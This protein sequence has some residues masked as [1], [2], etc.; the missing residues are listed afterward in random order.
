ML[1]LRCASSDSH[2]LQPLPLNAS[3]NSARFPLPRGAGRGARPSD[4]PATLSVCLALTA[5][6]N[7]ALRSQERRFAGVVVQR[8]PPA[9]GV[10]LRRAFTALKVCVELLALEEESWG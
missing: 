10:W 6:A 3:G 1:R 2:W 8:F 7:R 4:W 9:V 5:S